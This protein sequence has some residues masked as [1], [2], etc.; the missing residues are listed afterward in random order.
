[1]NAKALAKK[2]DICTVV[3][4]ACAPGTDCTCPKVADPAKFKAVCAQGTCRRKAL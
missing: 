2:M 4:C 1:M 3:E